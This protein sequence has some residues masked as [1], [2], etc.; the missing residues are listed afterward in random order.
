MNEIYNIAD[1]V[2]IPT[3]INEGTSL[4]CIESMATARAIIATN[5]GGL[6]E[7]YAD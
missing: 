4:A 2:V 3:T 1:I 7:V 5:V 6:S